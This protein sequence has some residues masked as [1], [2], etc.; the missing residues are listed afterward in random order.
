MTEKQKQ[1]ALQKVH[2]PSADDTTGTRKSRVTAAVLNGSDPILHQ[3]I[4]AAV[5]WIPRDIL[6]LKTKKATVIHLSGSIV[7]LPSNGTTTT[8]VVPSN[9]NPTKPHLVNV[10]QLENANVI[11][12]V[13]NMVP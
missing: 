12:I 6:G 3:F 4:Q 5:D 9:D 7:Q 1:Q 13:Q 11:I 8:L 10:Y 2:I